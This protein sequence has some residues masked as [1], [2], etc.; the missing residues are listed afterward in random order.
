MQH[1]RVVPKTN[2][3]LVVEA[4]AEREF[5][6][7]LGLVAEQVNRTEVVLQVLPDGQALV[8][9]VSTVSVTA[10]QVSDAMHQAFRADMHIEI[11]EE[12]EA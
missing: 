5:C 9:Y 10:E 7:A 4:M 12:Q 3:Q 2:S 11:R 8:T 6:T 1:I